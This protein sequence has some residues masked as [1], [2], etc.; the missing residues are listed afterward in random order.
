MSDPFK[1][2]MSSVS[3]EQF[4][5]QSSFGLRQDPR[6]FKLSIKAGEFAHVFARLSIDGHEYPKDVHTLCQRD[7]LDEPVI[8]YFV[9]PS[10]K[11]APCE[12]IIYGKTCK[13]T[14]YQ[15]TLCVQLSYLKI[16][17]LFENK[18]CVLLEPLQ[19]YQRKDEN[20]VLHVVISKALQ[21]K[22]RNGDSDVELSGNEYHDGVPKKKVK[23][24]GNIIVHG[25]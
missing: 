20:T 10:I 2:T 13:E 17:P 3:Y 25:Q 16:P 11:N 9:A 15:A 21:V 1:E 12:L 7:P 5:T 22:T 14:E 24:Q 23:V 4:T 18:Q 19:R 6:P 8:D